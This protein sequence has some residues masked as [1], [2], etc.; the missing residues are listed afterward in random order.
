[1]KFTVTMADGTQRIIEAE[2]HDDEISGVVVFYDDQ[3]NE[4][5][6]LAPGTWKEIKP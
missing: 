2:R 1:V 3:G 5:A 6:A 4:V